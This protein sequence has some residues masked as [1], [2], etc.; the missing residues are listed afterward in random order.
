[1]GSSATSSAGSVDERAGD[2]GALH[3]AARELLRVVAEAMRDAHT[4]RPGARA[5]GVAGRHPAQQAGQGDV[6]GHSVSVGSRLKNW[7][8]KPDA[9]APQPRQLIVSSRPGEIAA[10][11]SRCARRRPVHRAAEVEQRRLAAAGRAHQRDEVAE[12]TAPGSLSIRS[13]RAGGTCTISGTCSTSGNN[14]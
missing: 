14:V 1:V 6:V 8:T 5:F 4:R 3:L 11:N 7:K 2:G 9:L 10:S 12:A 13:A